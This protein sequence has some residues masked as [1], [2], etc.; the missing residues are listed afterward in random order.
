MGS[1]IKIGAAGVAVLIA[2]GLLAP[3]AS[4]QEVPAARDC[5][6]DVGDPV[7]GSP[8]WQAADDNNR[9]CAIEGLLTYQTN[10]AQHAANRANTAMGA[11][12]TY[13]GDPFREPFVRWDG[14]RGEVEQVTFT[15]RAGRVSDGLLFA[16][17]GDTGELPGIVIPCHACF[18]SAYESG[19]FWIA[20]ALAE[21]GYLVFVPYTGGNDADS[22]VDATDWLVSELN[23]LRHRLDPSRLGIAGHSGAGGLALT[24]GHSDPRFSAVV[25]FDPAGAGLGGLELRTPTM[26]QVADYS[27]NAGRL[28]PLPGDVDDGLPLPVLTFLPYIPNAQHAERPTPAPGSRYTY[29]DSLAAA[30]VDAMQV[31]IRAA[32]HIDWGRPSG[33]SFSTYGEMVATYYTLAWF[34][35]YLQ[36]ERATAALDRLRA[37]GTFDGSADAYSIGTGFFDPQ[38]AAEVGDVEAGNVP[39]TIGGMSVRSRLSFLYPTRYSLDV[40]TVQCADVRTGCP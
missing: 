37:T 35:R 4:A 32:T 39:I 10:P 30:G 36:P 24:V 6:N 21:A 19:L 20:E 11:T 31:G 13:R 34:D 5:R 15:N 28:L 26:V 25:A 18:T 3:V 38:R 7:S 2:A 8:E 22:T 27:G 14:V 17:P 29:F 40:G 12:P 9:Y 16:P 23:P 1:R 33:G